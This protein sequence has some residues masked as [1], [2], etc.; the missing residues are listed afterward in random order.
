MPRGGPVKTE[1]SRYPEH[2][3]TGVPKGGKM[4]VCESGLFEE[5]QEFPGGRNCISDLAWEAALV[6]HVS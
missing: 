5:L 4:T 1:T 3:L 6:C 2:C